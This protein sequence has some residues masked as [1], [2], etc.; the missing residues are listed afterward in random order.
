MQKRDQLVFMVEAIVDLLV[1]VLTWPQGSSSCLYVN[2]SSIISLH[3]HPAYAKTDNYII[4]Y[5]KHYVIMRNRG[6]KC[7][8]ILKSPPVIMLRNRCKN[9][10]T[11]IKCQK[12]RETIYFESVSYNFSSFGIFHVSVCFTSV[13]REQCFACV[14][15]RLVKV[16]SHPGHD[17]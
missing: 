14:Y 13:G 15:S 16:L 11:A 1:D 6:Q 8:T 2:I 12:S 7:A 5:R 4:S 10:E 9:M 17:H 3:V